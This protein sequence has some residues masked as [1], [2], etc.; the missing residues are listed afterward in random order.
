MKNKTKELKIVFT[1]F[2]SFSQ[3]NDQESPGQRILLKICRKRIL[4][5]YREISQSLLRNLNEIFLNF[6]SHRQQAGELAQMVERSLSMREVPGSIPGFSRS[7]DF[8]NASI[9]FLIITISST[10]PGARTASFFSNILTNHLPLRLLSSLLL[11]NT[12]N[13]FNPFKSSQYPLP[14]SPVLK[15]PH[16]SCS[17]NS[18]GLFFVSFLV[19]FSL[20][21]DGLFWC[22]TAFHRCHQNAMEIFLLQSFMC[23]AVS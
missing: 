15:S 18:S 16:E 4:P 13:D 1:E 14:S 7:K 19:C 22:V 21:R 2:M 11:I 17:S 23:Q 8:E 9:Q 20:A 12:I 5:A 10:V 3:K 6:I